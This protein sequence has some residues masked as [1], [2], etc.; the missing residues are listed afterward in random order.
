MA[1][2]ERVAGR[3]PFNRAIPQVD[4][5]GGPRWL[6]ARVPVPRGFALDEKELARLV[7]FRETLRDHLAG[8]EVTA[9][10]NEFA[11]TVAAGPRWSSDG[12]ALQPA[13]EGHGRPDRATA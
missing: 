13:G 8:V 7:R 4:Q 2:A 6:I 10:L 1:E 9:T 5:R 12:P 3:M 11:A